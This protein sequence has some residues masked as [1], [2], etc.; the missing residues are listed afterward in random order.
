M[1]VDCLVSPGLQN[2]VERTGGALC[3][4]DRQQRCLGALF[5][6]CGVVLE[7]DGR[8]GAI[9][10]ADGM[11]GGGICVAAQVFRICLWINRT[12]RLVLLV[13]VW[14]QEEHW[15]RADHGLRQWKGLDQKEPPK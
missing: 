1:N 6:I 8:G 5:A 13:D 12:G 4:P 9:V 7:I 11:H 15:I 14:S 3:T 2:V 10:L